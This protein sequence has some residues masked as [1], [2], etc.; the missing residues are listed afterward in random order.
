MIMFLIKLNRKTYYTRIVSYAN[1]FSYFFNRFIVPVFLSSR[2]IYR[3]SRSFNRN[4]FNYTI[5]GFLG[6]IEVVQTRPSDNFKL[7]V[8]I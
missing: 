5:H 2:E 7:L 8:I 4:R 6:E 3:F 1:W